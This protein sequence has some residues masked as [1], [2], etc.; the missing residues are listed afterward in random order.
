MKGGFPDDM[1]VG[2]DASLSCCARVSCCSS[3]SSH[4]DFLGF[5]TD[6]VDRGRVCTND[7]YAPSCLGLA[8]GIGGGPLFP[9]SEIVR[10]CVGT[11]ETGDLGVVGFLAGV[12]GLLCCD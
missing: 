7:E 3:C 11:F 6:G 5:L 4:L 1:L 9:A 8:A 12:G 2:E 10:I